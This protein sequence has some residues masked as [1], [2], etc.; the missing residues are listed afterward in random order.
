[1]THDT[2]QRQRRLARQVIPP[3]IPVVRGRAVVLLSE[4]G[5]ELARLR[6]E[7]AMQ[8]RHDLRRAAKS[9]GWG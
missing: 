8:L 4:T 2:A 7:D 1:M 3:V 6:P 9:I 5:D